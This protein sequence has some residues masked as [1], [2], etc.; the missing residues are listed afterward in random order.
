MV[1]MT[2]AS[3]EPNAAVHHS[4]ILLSMIVKELEPTACTDALARAGR[5]AEEQMAFYQRRSFAEDPQVRVFHDLR[6]DQT[7]SE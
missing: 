1:T 5:R 6:L 2:G 3:M 4:P 7:P